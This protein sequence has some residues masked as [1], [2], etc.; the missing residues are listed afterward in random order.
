MEC[1]FCGSELAG[2]WTLERSRGEL[3]AFDPWL[4]R[5]WSVCPACHGWNVIPLED[6]WEVL[7]ACER[8]AHEGSD[9]LL[10]TEQLC[11][12]HT[13][14]GRL[15]RIGEPP[16]SELAGWRYSTLLDP[17][18]ER[19]GFLA[20]LMRLPPRP[21]G[22]NIGPDFHGGVVTVPLAWAGSPFIEQSGL[23]TALY[24]SVPLA[25][26]CPACRRP[27]LIAPHTFGDLRLSLEAGDPAVVAECA[28]CASPVAI[29]V[30][31]ARPALR[32]GLAVV[33]RPHREPRK[34]GRAVLPIDRGGG[35]EEYIRS[36][37]RR[38]LQFAALSPR[39][40]LA[41]WLALDE[42]SEAEAL[43]A[44]W[45]RGEELAAIVDGELTEVPGFA[46]FRLRALRDST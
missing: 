29:A 1:F 37:A 22:G 25:A 16:R 27:L 24:A 28:L 31:S 9:V 32:A 4:G 43:E 3:I 19:R 35:P 39:H 40:R 23:L 21:A 45:R 7:E 36:L 38:D 46:E 13:R 8:A 30:R 34:V 2:V 26:I 6:R 10:R 44:E 14:A 41:L 18:S 5:L 12:L 17:W 15:I 42:A 33:N 11:L 20:R